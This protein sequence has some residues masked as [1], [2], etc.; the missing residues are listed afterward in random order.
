V[1]VPNKPKCIFCGEPK[2]LTK[3]HLWSRWI[4]QLVSHD[5]KKHEHVNQIFRSEGI[6]TA[7]RVWSGDVRNRG[8]RSVCGE[9]NNGWMS[10]LEEHARPALEPLI[11]GEL[12]FLNQNTQKTVATWIAM[13][14][15]IAEYF[16]PPRVA[17]P[18]IERQFLR[19]HR[20]PPTENWRIWIGNYERR[21][22]NAQWAHSAAGIAPV[23]SMARPGP[24]IPNTQ[25]TTIIVGK[26]YAHI[27][28]SEIQSLVS[29]ASLG[30][31]GVERLARI[32]PIQE[33]FIV[34]P[35]RPMSDIEAS[36]LSTAILV[37]LR[38][39]FPPPS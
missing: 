18:L 26:L 25:T 27:F 31:R 17:V 9:C 22:W 24:Q 15:M 39:Q 8:V 21:Q 29:R 19:R 11:K 16:D 12:F 4:R 34:W 14:T 33:D 30:K 5:A 28:S 2:K 13:K 32:W 38:N 1:N 7:T 20:K 3:E 36:E 6:E 10:S 35:P 37:D 23:T